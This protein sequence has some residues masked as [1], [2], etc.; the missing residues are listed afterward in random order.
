M[1]EAVASR[2]QEGREEL[3]HILKVLDLRFPTTES[4]FL[5]IIEATK[6][7]HFGKINSKVISS[8][9]SSII[10]QL[11]IISDLFK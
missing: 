2:V 1:Q 5:P 9:K 4:A 11:E 6:L 3:L 7:K 8:T 10:L